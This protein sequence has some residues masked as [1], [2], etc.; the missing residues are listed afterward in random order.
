M[1]ASRLSPPGAHTQEETLVIFGDFPRRYQLINHIAG[2][3]L[4][5]LR[6]A[7][8]WQLPSHLVNQ[9]LSSRLS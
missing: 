3:D 7:F 1:V 5:V 2:G 6:T 8:P 4:G 9:A